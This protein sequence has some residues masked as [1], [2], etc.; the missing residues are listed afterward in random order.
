MVKEEQL[1]S[2]EVD[3]LIKMHH[4]RDNFLISE[5]RLK[6][7]RKKDLFIISTKG[8]NGR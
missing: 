7:T 5:R 2:Y 6:M 3:I 8:Q 1:I 4:K